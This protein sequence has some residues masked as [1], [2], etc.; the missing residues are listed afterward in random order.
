MNGERAGMVA[1]KM[2]LGIQIPAS[3]VVMPLFL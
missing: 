3:S 1:L 2:M